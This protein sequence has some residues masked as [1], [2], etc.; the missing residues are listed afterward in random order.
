MRSPAGDRFDEW[1]MLETIEAARGGA[2]LI[3]ALAD[4]VCG[5]GSRPRR[6]TTSRSRRSGGCPRRDDRPRRRP[7]N[8]ARG[9][10]VDLSDRL[11]SARLLDEPDAIEEVHLAYFVRG[12]GGDHGQLPGE[13]EGF[14]AA[15]LDRRRRSKR[16]GAASRSRSARER[17]RDE[18][19]AA[20]CRDPGRVLSGIGGAVR[21]ML[22]DGSEYRGDYDPGDAT[23]WRTTGRGSM[24]T[25]R[26]RRRPAR[27][28]DDPDRPRARVLVRL[29]DETGVP[30]W[31]SYTGRDGADRRRR[32]VRRGDRAGWV[33]ARCC[34]GGRQLHRPTAHARTAQDRAGAQPTFRWYCLSEPWRHVGSRSRTCCSDRAGTW[35]P[36]VVASWTALGAAWLGGCCGTRPADIERLAAAVAAVAWRLVQPPVD[37][38]FSQC[39]VTVMTVQY[40]LLGLLDEEPRHGY[41]LK[42]AFDRVLSPQRPLPFGQVYASLAR[43]ERDGRVAIDGVERAVGL[44]RKRY[45]ITDAG[46]TALRTWPRSRSTPSRISRPS[47]TSRSS[48]RSCSMSR[49]SC[50]IPSA[51]PTSRGWFDSASPLGAIANGIA[52]RLRH[53]PPGSGPALARDDHRARRR[54]ARP[55]S[56]PENP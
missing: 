13:V 18:E 42:Q 14:A 49:S 50:S 55:R 24:R 12:T 19:A 16:S 37:D 26:G 9:S 30:A 40:A 23:P 41:E 48:W 17:F 10:R 51:G 54:A 39:I 20:G 3:T 44:D 2:Q 8:R 47:C 36:A 46:R 43:L 21:A 6:S 31:I 4:T 56:N 25:C 35:E 5:N 1:R 52:R 22:A 45:A 38:L 34:C 15:G 11:W 28:R 33:R 7:G 53:L 32:A 27:R 29:L